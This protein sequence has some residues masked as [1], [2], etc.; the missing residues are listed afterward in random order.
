MIDYGSG[1]IAQGI[2]MIINLG[3]K[4]MSGVMNELYILCGVFLALNVVYELFLLSGS[5]D[6]GTVIK[7]IITQLIIGIVILTLIRIWMPLLNDLIIPMFFQ[8]IP[9]YIFNFGVGAHKLLS[10]GE[11][12]LLNL[13]STWEVLKE[14]PE[15]IGKNK[16]GLMVLVEWVLLSNIGIYLSYLALRIITWFIVI[17]MFADIIREVLSIHLMFTFSGIIFPLMTFKPFREQ[18]GFNI[19][20][21]LLICTIQ[22]YMLFLLIG[23]I[24][25]YMSFLSHNYDDMFIYVL[26]VI[27][28]KGMFTGILKV[29]HEAGNKL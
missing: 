25:G 20:K 29:I 21:T 18:Y 5:L 22:Y 4:T 17:F 8:K 9:G 3:D 10:P 26:G 14:I 1:K 24:T 6:L 2:E 11:K 19:I 28:L 13:D 27:L 23:I 15:K 16:D 7:K 12:T